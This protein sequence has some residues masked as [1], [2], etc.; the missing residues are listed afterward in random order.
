VSG[1]EQQSAGLSRTEDWG[2]IV[3]PELGGVLLGA[4][5]CS[6]SRCTVGVSL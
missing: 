1:A 3:L 6:N 4:M 5:W 2:L